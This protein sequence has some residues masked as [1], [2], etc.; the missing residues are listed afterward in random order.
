[1]SSP[2]SLLIRFAFQWS[3]LF[4]G[5]ILSLWAATQSRQAPQF[6]LLIVLQVISQNFSVPA[7]QLRANLLPLVG[8]TGVLVLGWPGFFIMT[9]I[10]WLV[11]ELTL[12]LW[13]PLWQR[14]NYAGAPFST[15]FIQGLVHLVALSAAAMLY[16][17]TPGPLPLS[18]DTFTIAAAALGWL[19][20]SYSLLV[21]ILTFLWHTLRFRSLSNFWRGGEITILIYLVLSQPFALIGGLIFADLG[22]LAFTVFCVGIAILAQMNWLSWQQRTILQQQESGRASCRERV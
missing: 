16:Q 4:T 21:L 11:A 22:L 2:R 13:K 12:P 1:M 19:V 20:L 17:R 3:L 15:R 5:L 14:A 10:G 6:I 18:P 9:L 8:I 7:G